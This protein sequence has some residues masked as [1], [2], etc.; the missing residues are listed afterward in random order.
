MVSAA[1]AVVM[2]V[3]VVVSQLGIA[4][5]FLFMNLFKNILMYHAF[6]LPLVE[7]KLRVCI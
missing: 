3:V 5:G 2:A 1:A 4:Y 7:L 6:S